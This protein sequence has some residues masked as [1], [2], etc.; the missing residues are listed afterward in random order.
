MSIAIGCS[1][2]AYL[3]VFNN[4]NSEW[5]HANAENIFIIQHKA[6]KENELVTFGNSPMPLGP[7]IAH[8]HSSVT[9]AVRVDRG[10][11]IVKT[12]EN[13]FEELIRYADPEFLKMFTFPLKA[14]NDKALAEKNSVILSEGAA[15]KY[16]GEDNPI[17]RVLIIK[18]ANQEDRSFTVSGVAE[19]FPGPSSCVDFRLLMAYENIFGNNP[20]LANDWNSFTS[21][22]FIQVEKPESITEIAAQMAPYIKLQAA[23]DK[24][25]MPVKAFVFEALDDLRL[26][27]D[28]VRDS[29]SGHVSWAP[30]I[31]LSSISI[32][33]L[34]L[35]SFNFININLAMAGAR[36]K[37]IGIRKV[38]GGNK[39][40][41]AIQFLTENALVCLASFMMA[42]ALTG[43][44]LLPGFE[45]IAGTGLTRNF[46]DRPDVWLYLILLLVA[47]GLISGMYPALYISSFQP[48]A[49]L[50]DK[51][52]FGQKNKFMQSLLGFQFFLAFLTII[53]SVGLTLNA[54]DQK[55]RDWGYNKENV[56]TVRVENEAQYRQMYKAA[57]EQ[58]TVLEVTGAKTHVGSYSQE[59]DVQ[60][61]DARTSAI[62]FDVAQNYI[63]TMGIKLH[64]GKLP[65]SRDAVVVNQKFAR[66]FAW[67][68]S[69][70]QTVTIDSVSYSIVGIVE[71]FHH[72]HFGRG[73]D[74]VIF[75]LGKEPEFTR[76]VMRT[77][78]GSGVRTIDALEK[79]WKTSF[80]DQTFNHFFQDQTFEGLYQ[81]TG[82]I[83]KMF[84]FTT[85]IAL[86]M[87]CVGLFGLAAQ[88]MHTRRKEICIRK[89]FGVPVSKAVLLVNGNF[90]LLLAIAALVATPLSYFILNA[91]LDS[92]Y[93]FRME[94]GPS[95]FIISYL[96]MFITVIITLSG[97][98][99]EII[100]TNPAEIL[101]NE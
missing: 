36:L 69:P 6:L 65:D 87:S 67:D 97:K 10:M 31:V 4:L 53:A 86:L 1:I 25:N 38:V 62:V 72:D 90:I 61:K 81:E 83:L 79:N 19:Q 15:K 2:I 80:P 101:R 46:A 59:R 23:A 55:N 44:L 84:I 58:P 7:A 85:I 60:V 66:V 77:E 13:E 3:F 64:S 18:L 76:L 78:A 89:I 41:L 52:R 33:L 68:D 5:F 98:I 30:V 47:V 11:G 45:S 73:I 99:Y 27:S 20:N 43:S 24:D 39:R 70:G 17:G 29:I 51:F 40:Q 28:G 22:T 71:D 95:S 92:I 49:I 75:R 50:R 82:G 94:V 14:G 8:D 35:A 37:E 9:R 48:I 100:V 21:A 42:I 74:P 12:N 26:H 93:T 54:I 16:F 57:M 56:L 34:L 88:R 32:F 63:K 91:L 96:L